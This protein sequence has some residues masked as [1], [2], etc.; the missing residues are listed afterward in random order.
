MIT[1]YVLRNQKYCKISPSIRSLTILLAIASPAILASSFG[2]GMYANVESIFCYFWGS[3]MAASLIFCL[4]GT[5]QPNSKLTNTVYNL[6]IFC[7]RRS[8]GLYIYHWLA[9]YLVP[10]LL[11]PERPT[12][13]TTNDGIVV[14][15]TSITLAT[16]SYKWIEKPFLQLKRY[17]E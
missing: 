10:I 13:L 5:I 7:G 4:S 8:Y 16:F 9:I 1:A 17:F 15:L 14:L 2:M 6:M 3:L 11:H 12:T